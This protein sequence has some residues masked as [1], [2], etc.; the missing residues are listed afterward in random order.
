MHLLLMHAVNIT[1][2]N[3]LL[4]IVK[5]M[6]FI[7][8][9]MLCLYN[10]C[11]DYLDKSNRICSRYKKKDAARSARL[12]DQKA[13]CHGGYR[14]NPIHIQELWIILHFTISIYLLSNTLETKFLMG[15]R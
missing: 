8:C 2:Q 1:I 6:Q 4:A 14:K 9:I 11:W 10:R 7:S 13:F 3:A 15:Y 5:F 12:I